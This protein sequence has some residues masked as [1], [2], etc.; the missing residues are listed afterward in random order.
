MIVQLSTE[1]KKK[2]KKKRLCCVYTIKGIVCVRKS[3]PIISK[4]GIKNILNT[5]LN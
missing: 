3:D 2:K 5:S 1:K 4:S